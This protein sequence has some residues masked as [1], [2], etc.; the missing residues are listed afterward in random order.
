MT[1]LF[2]F[3]MPGPMEMMIILAIVLLLF[4]GARLPSLMR[5]LG[6][7]AKE[8]QKGVQGVDDEDYDEKPAREKHE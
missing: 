8:F 5:N 7:S 1:S 2:A 3:G 4:G 6:R